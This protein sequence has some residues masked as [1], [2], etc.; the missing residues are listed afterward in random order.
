[1]SGLNRR[2]RRQKRFRLLN[3]RSLRCLLF[4]ASGSFA[5]RSG[6]AE[7]DLRKTGCWQ[8]QGC[9]RLLSTFRVSERL[10]LPK[11]AKAWTTNQCGTKI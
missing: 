7:N 1:M 4:K 3:L 9:A 10:R 6:P 5:T 2:K 11:H 8:H